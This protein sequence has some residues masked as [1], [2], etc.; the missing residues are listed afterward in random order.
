MIKMRNAT[1]TE[2]SVPPGRVAFYEARKWTR[3]QLK[4]KGPAV[5]PVQAG[6]KSEG[7][8]K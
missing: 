1:G 5:P 8:G 2:I 7:A 3:V 4:P 6:N